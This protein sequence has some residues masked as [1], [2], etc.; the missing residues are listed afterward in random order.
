MTPLILLVALAASTPTTDPHKICQNAREA[1][2]AADQATAYEACV[3][4]E[5]AARDEM[6]KN[7]S[8]FST[9]ARSTC[10]QPGAVSMSYVEML[11]LPRNGERPQF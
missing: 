11:D 1:A 4:D 5:T 7:W 10:S 9:E 6:K 3:H 8:H 2:P